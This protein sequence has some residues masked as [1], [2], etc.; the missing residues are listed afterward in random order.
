MRISVTFVLFKLTFCRMS[1]GCIHHPSLAFHFV[2]YTF[3]IVFTS[4]RRFPNADSE[5]LLCIS[6]ANYDCSIACIADKTTCIL[7]IV[8]LSFECISTIHNHFDKSVPCL[9]SLLAS[10]IYHG[11]KEVW[12]FPPYFIETHCI[13]LCCHGCLCSSWGLCCFL[14]NGC[15]SIS[16]GFVCFSNDNQWILN[17]RG[18]GLGLDLRFTG[19]TL[20]LSFLLFHCG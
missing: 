15:Y 7:T 12:F 8:E 3:S 2:F 17:N 10:G 11:S 1:S 13:V 4:I 6:I 9:A 14:V 18:L 5:E 16:F 20:K 19:L